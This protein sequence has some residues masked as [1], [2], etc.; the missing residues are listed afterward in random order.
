MP[1]VVWTVGLIWCI[2][3]VPLVWATLTREEL[4]TAAIWL[5]I[6]MIW[7]VSGGIAM[8]AMTSATVG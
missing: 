7:F 1:A 5:A 8:A 6:S 3:I 4:R 2:G